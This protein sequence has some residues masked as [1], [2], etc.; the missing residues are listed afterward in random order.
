MK[1]YAVTCL[2]R[3]EFDIGNGVT[4]FDTKEKAKMQL[5]EEIKSLMEDFDIERKDIDITDTS[6]E[7][8]NCSGQVCYIN[9]EEKEVN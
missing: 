7:F 9:I 4:I 3:S 6:A 5:E 2:W 1:V 8:D